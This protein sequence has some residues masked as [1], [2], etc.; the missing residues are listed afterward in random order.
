LLLPARVLYGATNVI[1]RFVSLRHYGQTP[2]AEAAIGHPGQ[3][4]RHQAALKLGSFETLSGTSV[5]YRAGTASPETR[6]TTNIAKWIASAAFS[7][8]A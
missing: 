5:L 2:D 7:I 1:G 4:D 3:P 6:S 8:T